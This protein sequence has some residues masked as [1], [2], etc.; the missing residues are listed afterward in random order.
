MSLLEG[1]LR[2]SRQQRRTLTLARDL[3]GE[4]ILYLYEDE[5][6]LFCRRE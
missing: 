2:S 4:K 3:I 5:E 1:C 6:C